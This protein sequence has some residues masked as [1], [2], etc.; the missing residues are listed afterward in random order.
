MTRWTALLAAMFAF[1]ASGTTLSLYSYENPVVAGGVATVHASVTGTAPPT[2][3]LTFTVDGVPKS[4]ANYSFFAYAAGNARAESCQLPNLSQGHHT[5]EVR[6]GGD[7]ANPAAL[8]SLTQKVTNYLPSSGVVTRNPYGELKVTGAQLVGNVILPYEGWTEIFLGPKPGVPGEALEIEFAWFDMGNGPTF[9]I[10]AGAPDQVVVFRVIGSTP[11]ALSGTIFALPKDSSGTVPPPTFYFANPNGISLN[12]NTII[13]GNDVV[14]D[15][16]GRTWQEGG[17]VVIAGTLSTFRA[18][19]MGSSITGPGDIVANDVV[20]RTFGNMNDP[21]Y[22]NS[23]LDNGFKIWAANRTY[24]VNLTVN[25][26]GDSP[27]FINLEVAGNVVLQSPS[28]WPAGSV[29]PKNSLPVLPGATR[30]ATTPEPSYGG[31]SMIVSVP[32]GSLR[33]ASGSTNDFV[34]PGAVAFISAKEIDTA[35]VVVDQGWTTSGRTFQGMF[36]DA[37]RIFSSA[38]SISAYS[39]ANN[40]VN[41]STFPESS[42]R[43]FQLTRQSDGSAAFVSADAMAPHLNSFVTISRAA[44]NAECWTCIVN[45]NVFNVP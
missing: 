45:G 4:C 32:E 21:R 2:G 26:Y 14:F 17:P 42:V 40:W 7:N 3:T 23:P 11:S 19:V 27:Q 34:F 43:T 22:P 31:G 28:A 18:E 29:A 13:S 9:L 20:V 33:L 10:Y 35:G 36:F 5:I 15:A 8:A 39:N 25:A 30:P 24:P 6:Y 1:A 37:P 38:G 41:F 44:A 12:A 16:L